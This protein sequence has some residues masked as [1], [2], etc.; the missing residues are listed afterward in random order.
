MTAVQLTLGDDGIL[1]AA[2]DLAGRPMNVVGDTLMQGIA[3]AAARLAEPAVKGLVLTS[4][5]ADFCA[6][7]D[8]DRMSTWTTP[9]EPFEASMAMK[10]SPT[11]MVTFVRPSMQML[12][13]LR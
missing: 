12:S 6:G 2:M 10:E 4:N 11:L 7:G 1:V 9:Q 8:L 5:K 13:A 3:E